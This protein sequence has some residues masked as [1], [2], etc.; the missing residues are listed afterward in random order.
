MILPEDQIPVRY[1]ANVRRCEACMQESRELLVRAR[2]RKNGDPLPEEM[3]AALREMRDKLNAALLALEERAG[4]EHR[5]SLAV[6]ERCLGIY[7]R[8]RVL[9]GEIPLPEQSRPTRRGKI[10]RRGLRIGESA[11][12]RFGTST[13]FRGN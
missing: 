5:V 6:H 8:F 2:A 4:D 9:L 7:R 10:D 11:F 1:R 3:D 12:S 13:L